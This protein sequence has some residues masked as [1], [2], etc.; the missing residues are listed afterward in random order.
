MV[1]RLFNACLLRPGDVQPSQTD[2]EVV[3]TFN[4]GAVAVGD[5]VV[6]L[7]RVAEGPR[8]RR[9][10][11]TALPRWDSGSGLV[12]DWVPDEELYVVD[13][14][15]VRYK[16]D[17][18][19]RLTFISH[20]LVIG[21]IDGRSVDSVDGVRFGPEVEYEE[22]GVEDPRITRIGDTFYFTYVAVSRHGAATALASTG[23]FQT[24]RRHGVIFY[25]ENKDVALFPE[26]I[27]GAYVALHRPNAATRFTAPEMWLAW[28]SDLAHWGRHEPLRTQIALWARGRTGAGTPPI[29]TSEGWLEIYH[30][31]DKREGDR[32]IGTYA[33]G[34]LLLDIEQPHRLLGQ[35]IGPVLRPETDFERIGF[36]PNVVFP[37]GIVE[38]DDTVLIYYG[39][40]DTAVGVVEL[41]RAE[42]L[43]ALH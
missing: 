17:G 25:P 41:S 5:E 4:P 14:R 34:A 15:V 12:V 22:Y 7:V 10:G 26:Q 36:V 19:V 8:E 39:A 40:A 13:Q 16:Q 21:S 6:L 33:A 3:G 27:D 20:L 37:T 9:A 42:M 28:S 43:A 2:L 29:R 23:D 31:N 32:G 1:K 30:G 18:S 38:R 35:S 24:F 11:F